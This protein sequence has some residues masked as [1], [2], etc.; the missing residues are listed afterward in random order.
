[1]P[2][3]FRE[4]FDAQTGLVTD[5]WDGYFP[6]YDKALAPYRHRDISL[7]EIGVQNGGSLEVHARYFSN[8]KLIV[9]CDVNPQCGDLTYPDHQNIRVV[10]GDAN[11]GHTRDRI[12][13]LS[14]NF[15]IIIDDGSHTCSDIILTFLHYFPRLKQGGLFVVE[16][17]C[18]SYWRDFDGGLFHPSS[19]MA[20]LKDLTDLPNLE[21]WGLTLTPQQYLS[22]RHPN[23]SPI[24]N[25]CDFSG[26]HSV[27]FFNSMCLITKHDSDN[28]AKLGQRR[29]RGTRALVHPVIAQLDGTVLVTPN[30]SDNP[31][32]A[33]A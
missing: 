25:N 21:H 33:P 10:I 26:I 12:A 20:F 30:Q 4:A 15:D 3:S 27:Q 22:A 13:A 32:S 19:S 31:W 18:T 6:V 11:A 5:K 29:V 14:P 7:L 2:Q 28:R 16:D 24:I 17:L 9:G 1:M 8:H 23:Y